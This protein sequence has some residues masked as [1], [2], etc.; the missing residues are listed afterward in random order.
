MKKELKKMWQDFNSYRNWVQEH[1]AR[2][3]DATFSNFMEFIAYEYENFLLGLD[4]DM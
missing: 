4:Q 2:D 1:E 3:I